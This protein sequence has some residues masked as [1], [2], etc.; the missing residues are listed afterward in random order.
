M[1]RPL[2]VTN[3]TD[4][5]TAKSNAANCAEKKKPIKAAFDGIPSGIS[6]CPSGCFINSSGDVLLSLQAGVGAV[7]RGALANELE[8]RADA[9][10]VSV[11]VEL[12]EL[13]LGLAPRE[14]VRARHGL[15]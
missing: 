11:D 8:E 15:D 9:V 1:P 2:D 7:R 6:T 3:G 5:P 10:H 13:H 4:V 12:W 14:S